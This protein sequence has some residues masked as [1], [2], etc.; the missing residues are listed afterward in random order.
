MRADAGS[1]ALLVGK[2][3]GFSGIAL[4]CGAGMFRMG[5]LP[6]S[7]PASRALALI[8]AATA[9]VDL[10]IACFFVSRYRR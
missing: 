5:W 3:L 1:N 9:G 6:F 2:V 7:E 8:F 10:M 4:T